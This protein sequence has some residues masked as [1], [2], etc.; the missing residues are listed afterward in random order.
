MKRVLFIGRYAGFAG[1]IERYAFAAAKRLSAEGVVVDWVGTEPASGAESF[2]EAFGSVLSAQCLVPGAKVTVPNSID[3]STNR[4]IDESMNRRIDESTNRR[5]DESE[6]Y[7]EVV[8]HKIPGVK[9]I[10]AL[11]A[12]FGE[13]L[14]FFAHDHDLYCP[15][16]HYYT[17]FGRTN[18]HRAYSPLRCL[19]CA[20]ASSPRNAPRV[21]VNFL[22]PALAELRGCRARVISEFMRANLIR[23][24]FAPD[25]IEIVP[26]EVP[27][28]RE[29]KKFTPSKT[30]PI[31]LLFAGQLIAGKGCDLFLETLACL[32]R[33]GAPFAAT[34][35]GDGKDRAK[36]EARSRR[37]GLG[38]V[39]AGW[40]PDPEKYFAAADLTLFT[41]RWQEPY[42]LVGAESI[43]RG[44]PVA[45]FDVG[46]VREWLRPGV[47]GILVPEG[48]TAALADAV[49][50]FA[51]TGSLKGAR[52]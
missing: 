48:D 20:L 43:A 39:F 3:E 17:P 10:R 11:K 22:R 19:F 24:G 7:D 9:A 16:R 32:R 36:L 28:V 51:P 34:V 26:P 33:L 42:G 25:R 5:I 47:N 44:T 1:G 12:R 6:E 18:C 23:N 15:R 4:Q 29:L 46:G 14:V 21:V 41:S 52:S 30:T 35:L 13:R 50:A 45:A 49:A 8:I 27:A 38:V 2:C 37:D 31:R 40:R